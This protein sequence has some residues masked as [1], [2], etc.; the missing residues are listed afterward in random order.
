MSS[1][2][3]RTCQSRSVETTV[4]GPRRLAG[5]RMPQARRPRASYRW[6]VG[7]AARTWSIDEGSPMAP[8]AATAASRRRG[9]GVSGCHSARTS[10]HTARPWTGPARRCQLSECPRRRLRNERLAGRQTSRQESRRDLS[11]PVPLT[12]RE[13]GVPRARTRVAAPSMSGSS[14]ARRACKGISRLPAKRVRRA[15][16]SRTAARGGAPSSRTSAVSPV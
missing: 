14:S 5:L 2:A 7:S 10:R 12:S 8:S 16:Q 13:Q 4:G 15:P 9:S 11:W 3:C 1:A 6:F